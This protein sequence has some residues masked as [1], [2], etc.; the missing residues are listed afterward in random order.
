M[1]IFVFK[2]EYLCKY[3]LCWKKIANLKNG[4]CIIFITMMEKKDRKYVKTAIRLM[5]IIRDL[6]VSIFTYYMYTQDVNCLFISL[7]V[8]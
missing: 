1:I 2:I 5:N 6:R 7:I 8:K 4:F 3:T